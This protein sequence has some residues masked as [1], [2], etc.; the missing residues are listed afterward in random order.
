MHTSFNINEGVTLETTF[1][2]DV[3]GESRFDLDLAGNISVVDDTASKSS[4][5]LVQNVS[6]GFLMCPVL[7]SSDYENFTPLSRSGP[8]DTTITFTAWDDDITLE[9]DDRVFLTY[10]PERPLLIEATESAGEFIRYNAT[11]NIID[12]D[13]KLLKLKIMHCWPREGAQ[14]II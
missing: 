3:K 8:E 14:C 13:S 2:K 1:G 4:L 7:A 9:Y 6:H 11:I 12:T 10:T 5:M